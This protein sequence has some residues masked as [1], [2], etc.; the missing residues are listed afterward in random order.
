MRWIVANNESNAKTFQ[1]GYKLL[2]LELRRK[3]P[4]LAKISQVRDCCSAVI[5]A[6]AA[7]RVLP[8]S[9]IPDEM[10]RLIKLVG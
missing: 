3:V 4:A 9:E 7:G 8:I 10:I 6:G 1:G 5:K 2:R